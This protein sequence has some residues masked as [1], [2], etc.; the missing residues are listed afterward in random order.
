M[1]RCMAT[2]C[3]NEV[4]R[5]R[6]RAYLV[7]V[8]KNKYEVLNFVQR[9]AHLTGERLHLTLRTFVGSEGPLKC[10]I[11]IR[12]EARCLYTQRIDEAPRQRRRGYIRLVDRVPAA[13]Q[14]ADPWSE[15][16]GFPES[17]PRHNRRQPVVPCPVEPLSQ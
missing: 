5:V 15:E 16:S 4:S 6:L 10:G 11:Q 17:G 3:L 1:L 13:V 2:Q 12:E 8:I 14:I 9:P 7:K